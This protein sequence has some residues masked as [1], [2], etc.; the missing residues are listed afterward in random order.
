[1]TKSATPAT[2]PGR[3]RRDHRAHRGPRPPT[4]QE[5]GE[6]P[7]QVLSAQ[8]KPDARGTGRRGDLPNHASSTATGQ[9]VKPRTA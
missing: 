6:G 7:Q 4:Q 2:R 8:V 3:F 5:E 1:M 9:H